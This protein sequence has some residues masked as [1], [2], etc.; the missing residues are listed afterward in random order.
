MVDKKSTTEKAKATIADKIVEPAKAAGAA[1]RASGSKIAEGGAT[2]SMKMI[3]QAEENA[4]EAFAA[5]RDAA[6]AKDIAGVMKVQGDYLRAQGSRSMGQAR[7]IG[8]M[9]AQFGKDAL[10]PLRGTKE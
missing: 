9:I 5:M 2:M 3:D 8:E 10:A 6:K 1:M 7:E 4:R